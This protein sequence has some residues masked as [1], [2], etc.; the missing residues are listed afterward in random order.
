MRD[1]VPCPHTPMSFLRDPE[2]WMHFYSPFSTLS[3]LNWC[4]YSCVRFNATHSQKLAEAWHSHA[5]SRGKCRDGRMRL[6]CLIA[7]TICWTFLCPGTCYIPFA[8]TLDHSN[9]LYFHAGFSTF[10]RCSNR[11]AFIF[12]LKTLQSGDNNKDLLGWK[13]SFFRFLFWFI[14]ACS[15]EKQSCNFPWLV[16]CSR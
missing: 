12:Y 1:A 15:D 14:A 6:K 13:V 7:Q 3:A 4:L 5:C 16:W 10:D 2:L 9:N 11:C 8:W